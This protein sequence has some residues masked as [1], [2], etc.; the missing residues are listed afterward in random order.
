V[1]QPLILASFGTGNLQEHIRE[2]TS[3]IREVLRA[4]FFQRKLSAAEY[5]ADS[6]ATVQ[7]NQPLP[8]KLSLTPK[9]RGFAGPILLEECRRVITFVVIDILWLEIPDFVTRP[10]S[11]H[12]YLDRH[13]GL[14]VDFDVRLRGAAEVS[15][16]QGFIRYQRLASI[17]V[18]PPP[19]FP[20]SF[21]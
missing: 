8:E 3:P 7:L 10:R 9:L 19:V 5:I 4:R 14:P 1:A 17:V 2:F 15:F 20:L 18:C 13:S 6:G 21:Y 12:F 11:P 16:I